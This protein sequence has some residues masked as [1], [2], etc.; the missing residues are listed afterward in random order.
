MATPSILGLL[1]ETAAEAAHG[2]ETDAEAHGSGG[3]PQLNFETWA[4]QIFWL[5]V[6]FFVLYLL[7]SR[8]AL[9]RIASVL[10]ERADAI[11]SDLDQAEEYRRRAEEAEAAY[12]KA[13]ADARHKAQEI[14]AQT[15]A[16]IQKDVDE[17]TARADAEI[18]ARTA[19]SEKH[20]AEIRA[21]AMESVEEV[22]TETAEAIVE[23]IMPE[24]AD[25]EALNRAVQNR[26]EG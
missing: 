22:A 20:I 26:L 3:L 25:R 1:A 5:L 24:M 23:A 12:D 14:A 16:D 10:E 13:L 18:S 8:V 7:M 19:E 15:R 6:A 17:A 9:P 4:S 21:D 11:A 2:T